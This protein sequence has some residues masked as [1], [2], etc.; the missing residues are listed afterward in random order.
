MNEALTLKQLKQILNHVFL[1][2]PKGYSIIFTRD[3][4]PNKEPEKN[5]GMISNIWKDILDGRYSNGIGRDVI[6][7]TPI[8]VM[9]IL[10]NNIGMDIPKIRIQEY[11]LPIPEGNI[12]MQYLNPANPVIVTKK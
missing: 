6:F 5:L 7:E 11:V 3:R 8:E 2:K 1:R 12:I 9:F 10:R 4:N